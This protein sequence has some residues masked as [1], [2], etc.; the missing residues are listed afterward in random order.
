MTDLT[1]EAFGAQMG[2]YALLYALSRL[3]NQEII[4]FR[5][6]ISR[7]RGMMLLE[8]FDLPHQ[9][10]SLKDYKS[11]LPRLIKGKKNSKNYILH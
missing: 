10:I 5:E 6:Y 11:W 2:R 4:F 7:G 8:N 9:L 3:F 1:E